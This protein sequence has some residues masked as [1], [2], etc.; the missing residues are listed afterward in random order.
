MLL[1][2]DQ[3]AQGRATCPACGSTTSVLPGCRYGEGEIA[4]FNELAACVRSAE[5][6]T[7]D[8]IRLGLVLDDLRMTGEVH[9]A[10]ACVLARLPFLTETLTI[11]QASSERLRL[12]LSM[13]TILLGQRA[14][15]RRSDKLP[16]SR[17]ERGGSPCAS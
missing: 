2:A 14:A 9:A 6:S 16:T 10:V 17:R 11:L 7:S 4:L 3:C 12:G 1:A 8:A 5:I 15:T 13:I